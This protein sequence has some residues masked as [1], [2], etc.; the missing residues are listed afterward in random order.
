MKYILFFYI[1]LSGFFCLNAQNTENWELVKE[2]EGIKIYARKVNNSPFDELLGI[3]ITNTRLSSIVSLLKDYNNQPNWVFAN[4]ETSLLNAPNNFEWYYYMK[5]DAPW[6]VADRDIIIHAVLTQDSLS[7]TIHVNV[8]GIPQY[9]KVNK[10]IVRLPYLKSSWEFIPISADKTMIRLQILTD[11]GGEVP[12]WLVNMVKEKAPL[13]TLM[14][15]REELK[16][17]K[18]KNARLPYIK[19]KF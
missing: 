7:H 15:M 14:L 18:Y 19:E 4:V 11:I 1:L 3:Y 12:A 8:K 13:N 16:K 17:D 6:P 2:K 9:L 5:T 10:G